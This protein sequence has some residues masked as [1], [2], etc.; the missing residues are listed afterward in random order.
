MLLQSV[1]IQ[2]GV[3]NLFDLTQHCHSSRVDSL[4]YISANRVTVALP[5]TVNGLFK[6]CVFNKMAVNGPACAITL[7]AFD[8]VEHRSN[9][10]NI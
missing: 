5:V 6:D 2:V 10:S 3:S 4:Q 7:S 9:R 1:D 8:E